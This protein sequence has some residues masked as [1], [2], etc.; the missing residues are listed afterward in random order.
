[1]RIFLKFFQNN[2]DFIIAQQGA[3]IYIFAHK[4][5][6]KIPPDI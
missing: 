5:K 6:K 2:Q 4:S 1:M 3:E